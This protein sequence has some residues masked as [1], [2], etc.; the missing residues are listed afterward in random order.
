MSLAQYIAGLN[1][2]PR[3]LLSVVQDGATQTVPVKER[4]AQSNAVVI[5][6]KTRTSL[7][8]NL[9]EVAILSP[10]SGVVFPGALVLADENLMEG[11]P[12]PI[13]LERKPCDF[14]STC[15]D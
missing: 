4:T 2:D 5:C 15:R 14:R 1:Y 13:A 7:K 9:S 8:K 6:T 12:T 11:H 10:S 3:V